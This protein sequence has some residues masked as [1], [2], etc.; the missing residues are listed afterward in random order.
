MLHVV[1]TKYS[2][3]VLLAVYIELSYVNYVKFLLHLNI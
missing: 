1:Q 2:K 3:K